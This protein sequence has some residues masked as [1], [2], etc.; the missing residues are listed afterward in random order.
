MQAI[1][2]FLTSRALYKPKDTDGL[3]AGNNFNQIDS[4]ILC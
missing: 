1:Q 4:S 3:P 2:M